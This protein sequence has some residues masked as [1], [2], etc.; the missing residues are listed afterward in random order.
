MALKVLAAARQSGAEFRRKGFWDGALRHL[1]SDIAAVPHDLRFNLE[2]LLAKRRQRPMFDCLGHGERAQ[3]V[4]QIVGERVQPKT[5]L[6]D[7]Q[8]GSS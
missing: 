8:P 6:V 7:T 1:E 2:W 5:L 3:E 4:A